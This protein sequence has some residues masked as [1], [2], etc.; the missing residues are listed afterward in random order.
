MS[1]LA[2]L[3]DW[4]DPATTKT[5]DPDALRSIP[6]G[7]R[8]TSLTRE[9]GRMRKLG[10]GE[11]VIEAGLQALNLEVCDPP[12]DPDEVRTIAASI[13]R[14]YEAGDQ[15]RA[16]GLAERILLGDAIRNGV[17]PPEQLIK[18][19]LY[20]GAIHSLYG[21]P[22]TGKS[23][24]A[25]Y[26]SLQTIKQGKPVLYLDEENGQF[27]QAE[28]LKAMGA[29]PE[30]LDEHFHYYQSPGV[31]LEA[32]EDLIATAEQARPALVVFDSWADFLAL[33]GL[34]ENDSV[35][36]T[37]WVKT[38]CYPLRDI[39][40]AV[41]LLDHVAKDGGGVGGRG[42]GAKLAKLD[43]AFKVKTDK[44]FD[45]GRMGRVVLNREK[46]RLAALD[47]YTYFHIGG[48]DGQLICKTDEDDSYVLSEEDDLTPKQK[49]TLDALRSMPDG[50][51][52]SEWK[53]AAKAAGVSDSTFDRAKEALVPRLVTQDDNGHYYA[54]HWLDGLDDVA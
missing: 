36:V 37:R 48:K 19:L 41:L 46:D 18:G 12:L 52:Y 45:R 54:E 28:R 27:M 5:P 38:L 30:E 13:A 6:V 11:G 47:R 17:E 32:A 16:P 22:G 44:P 31:T 24:L 42:S 10:Y 23:I 14:N 29:T 26:M 39:G 35:D 4:A 21:P 8:N 1:R 53:A 7:R 9:A 49:D 34:N 40:A 51:S 25:L 20:A 15:I 43:A 50:G 33:E 3:P 2:A